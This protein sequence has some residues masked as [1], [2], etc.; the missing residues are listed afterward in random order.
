MNTFAEYLKK[1]YVCS[2]TNASLYASR[3]HRVA[4][5]PFIPLLSHS[6]VY[7]LYG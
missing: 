4:K 5:T 2:S 1:A 6:R 7:A 3:T